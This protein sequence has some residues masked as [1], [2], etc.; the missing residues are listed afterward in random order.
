[1]KKV[2]IYFSC[3]GDSLGGS[4]YLPLL[5]ISELQRR[6]DVTL[7][8]N[9]QS[10]IAHIARLAGLSI[11]TSNLKVEY[12]KP[13]GSL[14]RKLDAIVPFYRVRRLKE[15]SKDADICI[16]AANI[17]DFGKPAHHFVYLMRHFGDNAFYDYFMHVPPLRYVAHLRRK[18]RTWIADHILRPVL[19]VRSTR[20]I[21]ADPHERIYPNSRY[22][23]T[24]MQ[25]FYGLFTSSVFY[26]P[27]TFDFHAETN[28]ARHPLL[29]VCIGRIIPEKRVTEII[30]IVARARRFA[31]CDIRLGIAG[32]LTPQ[33]SYT[34][35]I[36]TIASE[37]EWIKLV[38]ALYGE[39]K[40]RFLLSGTYAIHTRRDEEFG[41][42]VAEYIKAGLIPVVPDE[43]G[44]PEV[45]D[46]PAL[47]YHTNEDAAQ[48][49][50][51]LI[52]DAD[53][54]ERERV[55]CAERAKFFSREAYLER[56]HELLNGIIDK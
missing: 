19:G 33:T 31:N 22:V 45:V 53:F 35:T 43:G 3:F 27:T 56:Q 47:T 46:S 23:E 51:N 28:P 29:V 34:K 50:A 16:S 41:I 20:Q 2:L 37:R 54:R 7:A 30:D 32:Q 14:L 44:T 48:I 6:C 13:K 38:G 36:E 26:P 8:L 18:L 49:L 39:E 10:D 1:M 24:T 21:L 52:A 40:E 55:H 4:E 25:S 9:W 12:V 42:A 17:I 15:L 11:D 5:F